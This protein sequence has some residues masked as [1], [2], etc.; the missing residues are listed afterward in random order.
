MEEERKKILKYLRLEGLLAHWDELLAE[1]RRGRC[2]HERLLKHVLEAEYRTRSEK[3]RLLRRKRAHIPEILEIET[4]PFHRQPKLD[5][6]RVMSLYDRFEYMTKQRNI[7]WMG[8]TGCGKTGLATG[9]LL[10][11]IDRGYRGYFILFEELLTKLYASL[12]DHSEAKLLRKYAAYDCLLIDEVG[13]LEVEPAQVALFF[14]LMQRRHKSKTTLISSNLGYS[15]WGSFLK[16]RHLTSALPVRE[17]RMLSRVLEYLTQRRQL[18]AK[19]LEP[20]LE[21]DKLYAD[22][23]ANAVFLLVADK[24]QRPVGAE[25]RGTGPRVW[26]GMAP[27][28]C[29]DSGYF[30][31]GAPGSQ[32]L[33]LCESAIDAISCCQIHPGR[34]CI[35]TA[36]ARANPRW[37]RG[38]I[39][40]GYQ[41]YCGFD[42]DQAGQD[43]AARM[44]TLH[45][46]VQRLRPPAHDGNDALRSHP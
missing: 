8:P 5:R 18:A 14:T 33:V 9:F 35:S 36:G 10:Q 38:L 22:H 20:L 12:A 45:P 32:E 3:A 25:L 1:A 28:T 7:I 41:I 27:G 16:N 13:Y 43:A 11:A 42:T 2:S 15:E 24:A 21:S 37:L 39:A 44:M 46:V 17:E 31:V 4:F 30:W 23:R 26:R 19:L 40:H 6:K 34:I 29:K